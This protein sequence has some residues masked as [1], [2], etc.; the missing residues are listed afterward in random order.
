ME[1]PG[2]DTIVADVATDSA[3]V[4]DATVT[5]GS[6][7]STW[8]PVLSPELPPERTADPVDAADRRGPDGGAEGEPGAVDDSRTAT[9][10]R[11]CARGSLPVAVE[12]AAYVAIA[13]VV[14]GGTAL[15]R[16]TWATLGTGGRTGLA[17][18]IALVGL[19]AGS[20]AMAIGDRA[21]RRLGG[22]LW[23]LGT[24]GLVWAAVVAAGSALPATT[25]PGSSILAGGAAAAV[26]GAASPP[27]HRPHARASS[28]ASMRAAAPRKAGRGDPAPNRATTAT[29]GRGRGSGMAAYTSARAAA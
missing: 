21:S 14:V 18:L 20:G 15:A 22:L 2:A 16:A 24:A 6:S 8:A 1:A 19:A 9:V 29:V 7:G 13:A 10:H 4:A 11:E 28:D 27:P 3:A 26:V 23:A 12:L 25:R 5:S 17:G